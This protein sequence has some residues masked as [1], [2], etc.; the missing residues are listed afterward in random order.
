MTSID[1]VTACSRSILAVCL[2]FVSCDPLDEGMLF[3][4][5]SFPQEA[6]HLM[7][8]N[9]NAFEEI[10]D[11]TGR[12]RDSKNGLDPVADLV[13]VAKATRADFGFELLNLLSGK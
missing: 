1:I 10:F 9:A 2:T 8:G 6:T 4:G 13:G 5:V 7:V 11:T 3:V 12:I